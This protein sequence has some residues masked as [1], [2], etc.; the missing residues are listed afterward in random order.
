MVPSPS[1]SRVASF[2]ARCVSRAICDPSEI[3]RTPMAA[4]SCNAVGAARS[5]ANQRIDRLRHRADNRLQSSMVGWHRNIQKISPGCVK[6]LDP[7]D[8]FLKIID[9]VHHAIS[10]GAKYKGP[11]ERPRRVH[12][13]PDPV[14]R[15]IETISRIA[16]SSSAYLQ[17]NNPKGQLH[18]PVERF[19]PL[20]LD[21]R[22]NRFQ[23]HRTPAMTSRK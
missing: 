1:I 10:A 18:R 3:R 14:N 13:C 22:Q 20:R 2:M 4:R 23:N 9:P 6:C 21:H 7:P 5:P 19:S 16:G 12:G 17:S 8:C 11:I 15:K